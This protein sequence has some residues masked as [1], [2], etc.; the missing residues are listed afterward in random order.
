MAQE[1]YH[2]RLNTGEDIISE[3]LWP[4]TKEG[5][6]PHVVLKHPM[7]IVCIPSGKPGYVSLSLMQWV[8]TKITSDQEFNVFSRDILTM[9]KPN[10]SLRGYY[11][12][13]VD[14]FSEKFKTDSIYEKDTTSEEFFDELEREIDAVVK[15]DKEVE[16]SNEDMDNL[17]DVIGEFLRS[18]SSNNRGTLH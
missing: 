4:E 7:K 8:F 17:R 3:V 15:S 9:S 13:T 14:Y 6:E 12:E 1:I 18:L 5:H 11:I 16:K 10:E 2:L